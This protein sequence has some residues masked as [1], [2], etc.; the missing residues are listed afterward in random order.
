MPND[1]APVTARSNDSLAG[2]LVSS[3]SPD[4]TKGIAISGPTPPSMRQVLLAYPAMR[5]TG[6]RT[7]N[8]EMLSSRRSSPRSSKPVALSQLNS[9]AAW[10]D[11]NGMMAARN[12]PPKPKPKPLSAAPLMNWDSPSRSSGAVRIE[13]L[14][15]TTAP[16]CKSGPSTSSALTADGTPSTAAMSA[17][18]AMFC[19]MLRTVD[20]DVV[21]GD[22]LVRSVVM[23]PRRTGNLSDH[24]HA[25]DH[26]TEHRVTVVEVW[27]R[28]FGDEEL[29]AV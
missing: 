6:I 9:T 23:V 16:I 11:R 20:V 24:V 15:P 13:R 1:R 5:S 7:R 3:S 28:S 17:N 4:E 2:T 29:A 14:T 12:V 22:V 21:D 26:L 19:G 10:T 27:R 25:L 18:S 8:V